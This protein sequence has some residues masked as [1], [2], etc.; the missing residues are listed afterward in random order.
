MDKKKWAEDV[1]R[2]KQNVSNVLCV[3]SR[4][5]GGL[6]EGNTHKKNS[7]TPAYLTNLFMY[8]SAKASHPLQMQKHTDFSLLPLSPPSLFPL[9]LAGHGR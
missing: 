5:H 9:S 6:I 1:K 3:D 8:S 7:T 2:K 4:P